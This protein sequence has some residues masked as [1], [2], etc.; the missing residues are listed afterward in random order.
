MERAG[1][2]PASFAVSIIP[3][4][5]LNPAVFGTIV[6]VAVFTTIMKVFTDGIQDNVLIK[7]NRWMVQ[8][9]YSLLLHANC[10]CQSIRFSRN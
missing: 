9:I 6:L 7:K 4:R 3:E 10:K 1:E 8:I 5:L 2:K